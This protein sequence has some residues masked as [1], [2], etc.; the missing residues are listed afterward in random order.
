MYAAT[1]T[2]QISHALHPIVEPGEEEAVRTCLSLR[3]GCRVEL[4]SARGEMDHG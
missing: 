1:P 3:A 4:D 2:D